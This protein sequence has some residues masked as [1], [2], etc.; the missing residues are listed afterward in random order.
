MEGQHVRLM[1]TGL[2]SSFLASLSIA[3]IEFF[4]HYGYPSPVYFSGTN[5][6]AFYRVQV[7][8]PHNHIAKLE[9]YLN[10]MP[11]LVLN[12]PVLPGGGGG[13]E[14]GQGTGLIP[15]QE[16]AVMFDSFYYSLGTQSIT[17]KC[18][19]LA[20]S[21][22]GGTQ[23]WFEHTYSAPAKNKAAIF[24]LPE[25]EDENGM[26]YPGAAGG[27][28]TK[29]QLDIIQYPATTTWNQGW[30]HTTLRDRLLEGVNAFCFV[31]H[32]TPQD[33]RDPN[34]G[35]IY[36]SKFDIL[37]EPVT[38]SIQ[39]MREE[40]IEYPWPPFNSS[41]HP[42]INI[43]AFFSCDAISSVNNFS[44]ILYPFWNGYG[45]FLE[46]QAVMGFS[47]GVQTVD[48]NALADTFWGELRRGKRAEPARAAMMNTEAGSHYN[49]GDSQILGDPHATLRRV[50]FP[51]PAMSLWWRPIPMP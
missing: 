21:H 10:N 30:T 49:P 2:L 36:L 28:R 11:T 4:P 1:L 22:P 8:A 29:A 16:G 50:Y 17:V 45:Q 40:A 42:A 7:T 12:T 3:G 35:I 26:Y 46:N 6:R 9:I 25:F 24:S 34:N 38:P 18:R 41:G 48:T 43:A 51:G 27:G 31:G 47:V 13:G 33:I 14:P 19:V 5:S 44:L 23:E 39:Q 32:G 20:E 37:G 15:V